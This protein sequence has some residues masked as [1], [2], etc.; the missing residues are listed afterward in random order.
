MSRLRRA[1]TGLIRHPLLTT[2]SGDSKVV[3][4]RVAVA[5]LLLGILSFFTS[6]LTGPF[7]IVLGIMGL[8]QF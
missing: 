8:V 1:A 7:G 6:G 5:A 3:T 4:S 2:S